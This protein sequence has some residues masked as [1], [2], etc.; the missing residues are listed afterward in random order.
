MTTKYPTFINDDD[1]SLKAVAY[2]LSRETFAVFFIVFSNVD[3]QDIL[4][5]RVDR[6]LTEG[7]TNHVHALEL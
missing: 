5:D 1:Q 4:S 6:G 3:L 7:K 2:L